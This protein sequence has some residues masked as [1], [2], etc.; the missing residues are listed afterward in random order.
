MTSISACS[1]PRNSPYPSV[2]QVRAQDVLP[3]GIGAVI[4]R[5]IRACTDQLERGAI[6]SVDTAQTG[7][8][9]CRCAPLAASAVGILRPHYQSSGG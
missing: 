4:V 8:G 1:W 5:T 7:F 3:S 9:Y 2:I 6:V